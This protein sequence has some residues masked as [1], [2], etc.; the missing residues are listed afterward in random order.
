VLVVGGG[1][2]GWRWAPGCGSWLESYVRVME[3]PHRGSTEVRSATYDEAA[4]A[5]TVV[6]VRDGEEL[7]LRPQQLVPRR[8]AP[9]LGPPGPD[10]YAGRREVVVGSDNCAFDICGALWEHG[11]AD[12]VADGDVHL[13]HG[14][15]DHPTEDVVVLDDGTALPADPV[16]HATGYGSMNGRAADPTSPEVADRVGKVWGPGSDTTDDPGPWE[17]EQRTMWEPT[18]QPGLWFHGGNLHQSRHHSLHPALQLEARQV[19]IPTP[20]RGLAEGHRTRWGRPA[21]GSP[22]LPGA[23]ACAIP[24]R[25]GPRHPTAPGPAPSHG[26][27][28]RAIPR[29]RGL[30][31]VRVGAVAQLAAGAA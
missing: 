31:G 3:I 21:P 22:A 9:L 15:V 14:Q 12:L 8:A 28:A 23:G 26:A 5:W 16:V 24:R 20:V 6:V 18:R 29:R 1:Q 13:V 7:T 17:G 19:G 27:G 30:R 25:R 2:G 10:G 4:G 11:A